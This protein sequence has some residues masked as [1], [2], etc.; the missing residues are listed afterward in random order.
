MAICLLTVATLALGAC[1]GGGENS[2]ST[3]SST[4]GRST[5]STTVDGSTTTLSAEDQLRRKVVEL[6]DLRNEVFMNPDPARVDEF[7]D[8]RCDCYE[9]DKAVLADLQAKG[10]RYAEPHVEVVGVRLEN[11]DHDGFAL[12]T[13]AAQ[14]A[15]LSVVD[16]VG[17]EVDHIDPLDLAAFDVSLIRVDGQWLM[18]GLDGLA[19]D[20]RV[21][22]A[23]VSE[24]MP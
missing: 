20:S 15:R 19:L 5:S 24:G 8:S 14:S 13:V 7:L 21:L 10:W 16:G 9:Q 6:F 4:T 22:A 1:R 2:G 11:N 23:V 3:S 17:R 12:F 18:Q